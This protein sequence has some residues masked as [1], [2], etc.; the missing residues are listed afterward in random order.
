MFWHWTP[1]HK[2][3]KPLVR[4]KDLLWGQWKGPDPLTTSSRWYACLYASSRCRV[5][6]FDFW[7]ADPACLNSPRTR[8][9]CFLGQKGKRGP[10]SPPAWKLQR[11][12][13]QTAPEAPDF[14]QAPKTYPKCNETVPSDDIWK[15]IAEQLGYPI[16]KSCT[17]DSHF[18]YTILGNINYLI[19]DG[20]NPNPGYHPKE[21]NNNTT[22]YANWSN[23]TVPWPVPANRWHHNQF[24]PAML[25]FPL[26]NQTHWQPELW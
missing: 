24:V 20:R 23:K 14:V 11:N 3:M 7:Q 1:Q 4:W 2:V 9:L 26:N 21:S 10:P 15:T 8:C 5:N 6:H 17:Y 25:S 13:A 16:W 19:Q 12:Q 22:K 18:S